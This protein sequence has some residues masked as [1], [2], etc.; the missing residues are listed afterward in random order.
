M[1]TEA[2]P[3]TNGA[4]SHTGSLG[5][6]SALEAKIVSGETTAIL[7]RWEF[8]KALLAERVGKQLPA[9]RL[10]EVATAVNQTTRELQYRMRLAERYPTEDKVRTAVRTYGSW[11]ALRETLVVKRTATQGASQEQ[12]NWLAAMW[13]YGKARPSIPRDATDTELKEAKRFAQSLRDAAKEIEAEV[14]SIQKE[15]STDSGQL[16]LTS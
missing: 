8:G 5:A 6:Y 1:T 3:A 15:R 11:T 9:G 13:D 14:A 16:A 7:A 4:G 2:S 10:G 12:K